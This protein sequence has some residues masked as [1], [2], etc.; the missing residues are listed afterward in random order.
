MKLKIGK[1]FTEIKEYLLKVAGADGELEKIVQKKTNAQDL[2]GALK[3]A[4][5]ISVGEGCVLL[6]LDDTIQAA[7]K[8]KDFKFA[9]RA[10]NVRN[11][12]IEKIKREKAI[13]EIIEAALKAG[14]YEFAREQATAIDWD[15]RRPHTWLAIAKATKEL[16]DIKK[17]L[18]IVNSMSRWDV[19]EQA[20]ILGELAEIA[21]KAGYFD[22]AWAITYQDIVLDHD[23]E[24]IG[25][26]AGAMRFIIEKAALAEN[27][28][29]A[30][31]WATKISEYVKHS[32]EVLDRCRAKSDE[33]W[34]AKMDLS[35]WASSAIDAWLAI[36]RASKLPDDLKI[37]RDLIIENL[38]DEQRI[39]K[40]NELEK[41]EKSL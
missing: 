39:D 28:D 32:R 9:L 33:Y 22:L 24:N 40:L 41:T 23:G 1:L 29:S 8:N 25:K 15:Y 35:Y 6:I 30:R 21:A 3:T 37:T 10:L 26:K 5:K 11:R 34:D 20:T 38:D 19:K 16:A 4:S 27:L 13:Q 31:K 2:E 36:S 18:G 12:K 17:T 7:L 14:D